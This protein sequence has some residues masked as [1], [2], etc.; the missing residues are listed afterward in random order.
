MK[1]LKLVFV[2]VLFSCGG[3]DEITSP[4]EENIPPV[5]NGTVNPYDI[6]I[7]ESVEYTSSSSNDPDNSTNQGLRRRWDFDGDNNWDT[8]YEDYKTNVTHQFDIAGSY[9]SILEV[10]DNDNATTKKTFS[11]INVTENAE[12]ISPVADGTISN[13]N[14]KTGNEVN[15]NASLS[16]DPDSSNSGLLRAWD[17]DGDGNLDTEYEAYTTP[18]S[19]I[20]N[21]A[22]N[23]TSI[24]KVKDSADAVGSK[25]FSPIEVKDNVAPSAVGSSDKNYAE[26]GD[27]VTFNSANSNDPDGDNSNL[28]SRWDFDSDGNFDT[29]YASYNTPVEHQFNNGGNYN[30]TLEVKDLEGDVNQS[31]LDN[32]GVL[33]PANN[34]ITIDLQVPKYIIAGNEFIATAVSTDNNNRPIDYNFNFEYGNSIDSSDNNEA[35]TYPA[36]EVG[37]KNLEVLV[38][39]DYNVSNTVTKEVE[40]GSVIPANMILTDK[41]SGD[42]YRVKVMQDGKP[43]TTESYKGKEGVWYDN[44]SISNSVFGKYLTASEVDKLSDIVLVADDGREFETHVASAAELEVLANMYGGPGVAGGDLKYKEF[45]NGVN[46]GATN[47]SGLSLM[48][49]GI[50]ENLSSSIYQ[51]DRGFYM[52]SEDNGLG[53]KKAYIVN[54]DN[55]NIGILSQLPEFSAGNVRLIIEN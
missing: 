27:T 26:I 2:F 45:A 15:Y 37:K 3:D 19:H 54:K 41:E 1:Y 34:P 46:V 28:K 7:G 12:N 51:G 48:L 21:Q 16:N 10:I 36:S 20:F 32:L 55:T 50:L 22:G 29:D 23:Y 30:P 38:K 4:I 6:K 14:I 25:T 42:K 43:W 49:G 31:V 17:Y 52:T 33:D 5:P 18:S 8:A 11:P 40:V 53:S 35:F 47:E 24:L 13:Y 39:N 9:S 44:D